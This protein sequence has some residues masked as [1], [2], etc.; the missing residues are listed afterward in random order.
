MTSLVDYLQHWARV[1]PDTAFCGFL[2]GDGREKERYTYAA[3]DERTRR[4][5]EHL[6]GE[7]RLRRGDCALLVYPPGLEIIVAFIACARVGITP[8]PVPSAMHSPTRHALAA[9]AFVA[10]D[11]Q[12]SAAL[13]TAACGRL[14]LDRLSRWPEGAGLVAPPPLE[15]IDT[16]DMRGRPSPS[17]R[18]DPGPSLFLQYTSGST[19]DQKGVVVS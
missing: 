3:F 13:S 15:W 8:V 17:F 14:Y 10:R 16:E 11:C 5:A 12:A 6:V 19:S 9:L 7:R 1:Q 18:D 2:D 4:L